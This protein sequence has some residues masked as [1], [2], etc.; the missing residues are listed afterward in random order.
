MQTSHPLPE[1]TTHSLL[2]QAEQLI[3]KGKFS[4]A[5]L[6]LSQHSGFFSEPADAAAMEILLAKSYIQQ[7]DTWPALTHIAH[8]ANLLDQTGNG[9]DERHG[10]MRIQLLLM[11]ANV[12]YFNG[13]SQRELD[14]CLDEINLL[15]QSFGTPEQRLQLYINIYLS[16]LQRYQWYQL[17]LEALTHASYMLEL[18]RQLNDES[19]LINGYG[20]LAMIHMFRHEYKA[21]IA[22]NEQCLALITDS[23]RDWIPLTYNYLAVTYRMMGNIA[24]CES[25][26]RKALDAAIVQQNKNYEASGKANL[27]WLYLQRKDYRSAEQYAIESFAMLT[28]IRHPFLWLSV[29]PMAACCLYQNK[30]MDCGPYLHALFFPLRKK[31]PEKLDNL[32]TQAVIR[33]WQQKEHEMKIFVEDALYEA[34]I[35][36]YL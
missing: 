10:N 25:W 22:A 36:G 15:I 29:M 14:T 1:H 2:Q 28:S 16:M 11:K 12:L 35:T 21:A 4:D 33:W 32:L 13:M 31:L 17:P 34:A 9:D 7:K 8:A 19:A 3:G 24:G 18:A 6:Y 23:H 20:E 27:A 30:V 26:C 5:R